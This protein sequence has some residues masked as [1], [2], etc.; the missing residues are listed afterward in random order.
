M[1]VAFLYTIAFLVLLSL[2]HVARVD[3]AS[4]EAMDTGNWIVDGCNAFLKSEA[5]T[6]MDRAWAC[7]GAIDTAFDLGIIHREVCPP[8]NITRSQIVRIVTKFLNDNPAKL[9]L[10]YPSLMA[11]ALHQTWPCPSK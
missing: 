10:P 6:S 4:Y 2:G 9:H 3:D 7:A 1:K 5:Q 8:S 11:A